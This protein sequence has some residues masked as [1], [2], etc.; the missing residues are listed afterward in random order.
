[1]LRRLHVLQFDYLKQYIDFLTKF[2]DINLKN[3]KIFIDC[4]NG[5]ASYYAKQIFEQTKAKIFVK[6]CDG[7]INKNASVLD[8]KIFQKNFNKS[9]CDIGFCFDGDAD[10]I[11]MITK[12]FG[13]FDGDKI[14][15]LLA[16]H[17][18]EKFVVG[19]IM[20][21]LGIEKALKRNHIRLF[22]VNVG[23]RNIAKLLKQK[24]YNIGAEASGHVIIHNQHTTGDGILTAL[25]LLK[26]FKTNKN[27]FKQTSKIK[28]LPM[29]QDK[30]KT[31]NKD[32]L[33]SKNVKFFL[34]KT[35]KELGKNGR[36]VLRPSGTESVIRIMV[37][38]SVKNIAEK[39]CS[40]VKLFI[41]KEIDNFD[42]INV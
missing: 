41:Q 33:K 6:N 7:E 40:N 36:L 18:K 4:A 1:M 37:E 23:D 42:K 9:N 3:V 27:L 5:A 32:I 30:I 16:R 14:L 11:M 21:N 31:T 10:R 8:N 20:T 22:R 38:H 29:I 28:I 24:S 15:Y 17:F 26:I 35:N 25:N 2:V 12:E 13:I 19:T 39:V 34:E